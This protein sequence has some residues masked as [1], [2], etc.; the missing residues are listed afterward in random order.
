M[1][2][3]ILVHGGNV[4]TDTWN[5]LTQS[6]D[7]PAGGKLGGKVWN[8]IIIKLES[9]GHCV[10]APTLQDEFSHNLS[11]H[12]QQI[13]ALITENELTDVILVGHSYAGMIIT[14]VADKLHDKI[15][16]LVYID[17]ALPEPNQS[18]F[19]LLCSAGLNPIDVVDGKPMAYT[20][21]LQFDSNKIKSLPKC[22]ILCAESDF[23]HV[24]M[25]AKHKI[26]LDSNGWEYIE[27]LTSHIPM[28]TMPKNVAECLMQQGST[29]RQDG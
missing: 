6:K 8:K 26:K 2:D 25:L 3:Y 23:Q 5:N 22:Y 28:A 11:D 7:H 10:Y 12:I 19:D 14:G 18:L 9:H 21:K 29:S 15:A 1:T 24:T 20:E 16:R 27:L 13:C 4:A 17:A